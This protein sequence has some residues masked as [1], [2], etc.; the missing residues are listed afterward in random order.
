MAMPEL[1]FQVINGGEGGGGGGGDGVCLEFFTSSFQ[2]PCH[3]LLTV[4]SM[5]YGLPTR[6]FHSTSKTFQNT[7]MDY[8]GIELELEGKR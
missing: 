7:Y 3:V 6:S 1:L 5:I 4:W 2:A 8:A